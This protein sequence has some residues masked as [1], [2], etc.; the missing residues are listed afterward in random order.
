[1]VV[2]MG[3]CAGIRRMTRVDPDGTHNMVYGTYTRHADVRQEGTSLDILL[4]QCVSTYETCVGLGWNIQ[5]DIWAGPRWV[6]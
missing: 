4:G 3:Q 5:H 2:H 6:S 1:M